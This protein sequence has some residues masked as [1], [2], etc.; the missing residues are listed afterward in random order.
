MFFWL[1]VGYRTNKINLNIGL[2]LMDNL[3]LIPLDRMARPD[4]P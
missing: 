1:F 4:L 2:Y 3:A